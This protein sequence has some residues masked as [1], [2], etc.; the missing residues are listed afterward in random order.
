MTEKDSNQGHRRFLK[1]SSVEPYRV[2]GKFPSTL[3]PGYGQGTVDFGWLSRVEAG[4]L[5]FVMSPSCESCSFDPIRDFSLDFP[6]FQYAMLIDSGEQAFMELREEHELSFPL[7]RFD[8]S[9]YLLQLGVDQ[10][11]WVFV[12][13]RIGQ[14][15][16]AGVFNHTQHLLH[17][18]RPLLDVYYPDNEII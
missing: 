8:T 5:V 2:G 7:I 12:L 17:I 15:V 9:K 4:S 1:G 18:A 6:A 11:P 14:V 13:N 3:E 10:I 16:G